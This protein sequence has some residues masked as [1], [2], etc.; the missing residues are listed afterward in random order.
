[1]KNNTK[2]LCNFPLSTLL[3]ITYKPI[4]IYN[5]EVFQIYDFKYEEEIE[6]YINKYQKEI[7]GTNAIYLNV[8][9]K[10]RGRGVKGHIVDGFLIDISNPPKFK[11]WL[12]E[13]ELIKHDVEK[14]INPQITGFI[15]Q[16]RNKFTRYELSEIIYEE[17]KKTN[18]INKIKKYVGEE[19]FVAIMNA[20]NQ[21]PDNILIIIDKAN[22]EL[23][24][25]F[26]EAYRKLSK[27]IK[28][29]IIQLYRSK[30]NREVILTTPFISKSVKRNKRVKGIIETKINNYYINLRK[31]LRKR[32]LLFKWRK[33]KN[34]KILFG[35]YRDLP[36]ISIYKGKLEVIIRV[37]G[38]K[39][40][41]KLIK[42]IKYRT[43]RKSYFGSNFDIV[44]SSKNTS[45]KLLDEIISDV[46]NKFNSSKIK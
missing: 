45:L 26:L 37:P 46:V 23:L 2:G 5:N 6:L 12:V 44:I 16:I 10:L 9:K 22:T 25:L 1:M 4:I 21:S 24:K 34:K 14:H 31:I 36:L 13:I 19:P 35:Y 8:K 27:N 20:I 33:R 29:L 43:A 18:Q 3:D 15:K 38:D 17:L 39:V 11:I 40:N 42:E 32:G 7:F 41:P 28:I 30:N